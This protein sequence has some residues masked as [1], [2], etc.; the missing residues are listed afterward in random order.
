MLGY[1][2]SKMFILSNGLESTLCYCLRTVENNRKIIE[3]IEIRKMF[4]LDVFSTSS[5]RVCESLKPISPSQRTHDHDVEIA[6][7]AS[8]RVS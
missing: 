8:N 5:L 4:Y 6:R 1:I 2:K 7:N 3:T